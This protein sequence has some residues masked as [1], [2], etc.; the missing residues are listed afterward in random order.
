M[1]HQTAF[2]LKYLVCALSIVFWKAPKNQEH[3]RSST[4]IIS[5]LGA[6]KIIA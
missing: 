3:F 4:E 6:P 5:I 2:L 1:S